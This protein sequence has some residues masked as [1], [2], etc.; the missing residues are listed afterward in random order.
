MNTYKHVQKR[1]PRLLMKDENSLKEKLS[2][3][4]FRVSNLIA[5]LRSQKCKTKTACKV[6]NL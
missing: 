2:H 1:K 6:S 5:Y 3:K 4:N